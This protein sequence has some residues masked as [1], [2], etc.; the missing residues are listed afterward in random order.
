MP[1]SDLRSKTL[2][3]LN[4]G[5]SYLVFLRTR[6]TK[7]NR[8]LPGHWNFRH[9]R[10]NR[11]CYPGDLPRNRGRHDLSRLIIEAPAVFTPPPSGR[12][13]FLKLAP[14]MAEDIHRPLQND[15]LLPPWLRRP[16]LFVAPGTCQ[17]APIASTL[18]N[19]HS[20]LKRWLGLYRRACISRYSLCRLELSPNLSF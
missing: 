20:W 10:S 7:P 12:G 8:C 11:R 1:P 4:Q 2:E 3:R 18:D 16:G 19:S 14:K 15:F 9:Q 17:T 13:F 5:L 6:M